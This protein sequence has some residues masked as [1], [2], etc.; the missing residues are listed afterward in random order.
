[1]GAGKSTLAKHM[2]SEFGLTRVA[3]GDA[4]KLEFFDSMR[5]GAV[6][7]F[8][9][10][11]NILFPNIPNDERKI[12]WVDRHKHE[13][14]IALQQYATEYRRAQD[15]MYWV[16]RGLAR[17]QNLLDAEKTLVVDDTRFPDELKA[18]KY[19]G[20]VVA[21]IK[22]SSTNQTERIM[23][24]DGR[25]D[26]KSREHSSERALN[27]YSF[28][29]RISNDRDLEKLRGFGTVLLEAASLSISRKAPA[30]ALG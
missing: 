4:M 16:K 23:Q 29:V 20:F 8:I 1:M 27:G 5:S 3:W 13:V 2:E 12:I 11:P 9:E 25:F 26:P 22:V 15:S 30:I 24:R 19:R 10:R 7:D 18:L 28:D 6:P 17:I 14:R 21:I